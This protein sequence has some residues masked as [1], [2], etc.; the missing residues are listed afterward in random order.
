MPIK[1]P[2]III[3]PNLYLYKFLSLLFSVT[4]TYTNSWVLHIELLELIH[5]DLV[6]FKNTISKGGKKYYITFVDDFSRYTK[7][8]LLKSKDE[9]RE[10]FLKYKAKV[11]NQLDKKIKRL[12]TDRGGEYSTKFFKEFC[13]INCIIHETTTPYAPQ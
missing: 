8:Y 13:E 1:I 2:V 12:R 7:V 10:M 9:D 5:L 4:Y 11:E 6:D 3:F